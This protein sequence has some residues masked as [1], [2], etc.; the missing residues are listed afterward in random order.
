ML[1][2]SRRTTDPGDQAGYRKITPARITSQPLSSAT[3]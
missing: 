2:P 1:K 3:T